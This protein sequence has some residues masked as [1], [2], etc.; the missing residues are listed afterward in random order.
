MD[1]ASSFMCIMFYCNIIVLSIFQDKF[2]PFL[3]MFQRDTIKV[4]VCKN[5]LE[6]FG[7]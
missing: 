5:V 1:E 6:A 4:E 2:L 3:D 7:R